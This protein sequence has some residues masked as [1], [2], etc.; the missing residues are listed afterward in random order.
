MNF[1]ELPE[2]HAAVWHALKT[3]EDDAK[4]TG[5]ELMKRCGIEER[6]DL[7]SI[8]EDLRRNSYLIGSSKS[9]DGGYF[10]IRDAVDLSK[11]TLN[12]RKTATS[13]LTLADKLEKEWM[14][15][16]YGEVLEESE[17]DE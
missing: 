15:K 8:I 1:N 16:E 14:R 4:I 11:T 5:D 3:L 6:R 17:D 7:Y 13:M 10:E 2:K 12:L 9:K